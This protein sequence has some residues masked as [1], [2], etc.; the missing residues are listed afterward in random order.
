M[1]AI[2]WTFLALC[3]INT[4]FLFA[5]LVAFVL[6][7]KYTRMYDAPVAK[8]EFLEEIVSAGLLL[9][10]SFGL[11]LL[12]FAGILMGMCPINAQI[13][14]FSGRLALL[15]AAISS[16]WRFIQSFA[17][18]FVCRQDMKLPCCQSLR[19]FRAFFLA[20]SLAIICFLACV[21]FSL[22]ISLRVDDYN[23]RYHGKR[24][25]DSIEGV[26]LYQRHL[27]QYKVVEKDTEQ[28]CNFFETRTKIALPKDIENIHKDV[29]TIRFNCSDINDFYTLF[30]NEQH[31]PLMPSYHCD[32]VIGIK[33]DELTSARI[34]NAIYELRDAISSTC[35][36]GPVDLVLDTDY[37]PEDNYAMQT[38]EIWSNAALKGL[39]DNTCGDNLNSCTTVKNQTHNNPVFNCTS[40]LCLTPPADSTNSSS[41]ALVSHL[42]VSERQMLSYYPCMP[43][44]D[45][46]HQLEFDS[47]QQPS[48]I[49]EL[50]GGIME[51]ASCTGA[52]LSYDQFEEDWEEQEIHALDQYN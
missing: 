44:V 51:Y 38:T 5:E 29:Y 47:C 19:G 8:S 45:L 9:F 34:V 6:Q 33:D 21:T 30:I 1:D 36:S 3:C 50:Q 52:Y 17:F 24:Y 20:I 31:R 26:Y 18:C 32:I 25:S 23:G 43:Y 37:D 11:P 46:H 41:I 16:I 22:A 49:Q 28:V 2:Y 48:N 42:L 4:V 27:A 7:L 35:I 39:F 10:Q 14:S 12:F 40:D 13:R 15:L